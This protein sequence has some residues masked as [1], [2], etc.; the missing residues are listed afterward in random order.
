MGVDCACHH[1]REWVPLE[2]HHVWPKGD[3]GPDVPTNKV[4]ICENAH[5]AIHSL[6][7][8]MRKGPVPWIIRRRYGRKVRAFAQ[9]GY[10][11]MQR[12]Y[13]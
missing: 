8:H 4:T 11:R 1:H 6:L 9:L 7:D 13:L 5:G 12:G 3:G 10:D 2:I